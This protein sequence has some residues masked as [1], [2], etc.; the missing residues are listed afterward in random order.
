M[1]ETE[2]LS[3]VLWCTF[4]DIWFLVHLTINIFIFD[5]S[6]LQAK[7]HFLQK[8]QENA[9]TWCILVLVT[10]LLNISCVIWWT[11]TVWEYS[12]VALKDKENTRQVFLCSEPECM[13]VSML[14]CAVLRS[15]A[16]SGRFFFLP[17]SI[18]HA[19]Q[20]VNEVGRLSLTDGVEWSR[21][22]SILLNYFVNFRPVYYTSSKQWHI[23]VS[24][25]VKTK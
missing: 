2:K 11:I 18:S 20:V 17:I 24:C 7:L 19:R 14:S 9:V 25:W 6:R 3:R 5:F 16:L 13:A 10:M 8:R 23:L 12:D 15:R 22:T 1:V 4:L 21:I